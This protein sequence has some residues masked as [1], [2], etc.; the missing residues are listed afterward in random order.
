MVLL[1][2]IALAGLPAGAANDGPMERATLRGLKS[3]NVVIDTLDPALTRD[4]IAPDSLRTRIEREI[5][6]ADITVD[7]DAK[8]FLG[9]RITQVRGGR[10]PYA[11]CF[12][13]GLYQPVMLA[14]DKDVHTVTQTWEVVSVV[15]ADPK[16]L[17]GASMDT[18]LDLTQRFLTAWKAANPDE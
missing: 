13:L 9:L 11:L 10:G 15:M 6:G 8:E 18:A 7:H 5:H 2:A 4:G 16:I 12:S 14:R 17:S 3:L 1:M